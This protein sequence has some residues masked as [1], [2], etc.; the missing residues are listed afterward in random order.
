MQDIGLAR[1]DVYFQFLKN[2]TVIYDLP[3]VDTLK[4]RITQLYKKDW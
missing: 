2:D 1:F 3:A 4:E